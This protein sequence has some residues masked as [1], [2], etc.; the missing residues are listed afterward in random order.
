MTQRYIRYALYPIGRALL[1]K[2]VEPG[3]SKQYDSS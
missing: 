2:M 1:T 3:K